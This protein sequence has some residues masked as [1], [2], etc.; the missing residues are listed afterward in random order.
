MIQIHDPNS[1][2]LGW[3]KFNE[4]NRYHLNWFQEGILRKKNNLQF[5]NIIFARIFDE[6]DMD[7]KVGYKNNPANCHIEEGQIVQ[8]YVGLNTVKILIKEKNTFLTAFP[9]ADSDFQTWAAQNSKDMILGRKVAYLMAKEKVKELQEIQSYTKHEI[10][11]M[12]PARWEAEEIIP[13]R[14]WEWKTRGE[15]AK[16]PKGQEPSHYKEN[17][18]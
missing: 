11:R 9:V 16:C 18:K 10:T 6:F 8:D 17:K 14:L 4:S 15:S 5:V 2:D 12:M 13:H 1:P 7:I 3:S